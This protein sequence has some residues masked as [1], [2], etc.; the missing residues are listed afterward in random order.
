MAGTITSRMPNLFV[1]TAVTNGGTA[2]A[3]DSATA[4]KAR[5]ILIIARAAN[6]GTIFIGGS[7]VSSSTSKGFTAGQSIS[8]DSYNQPYI[9]ISDYYLDVSG[10]GE[11]IDYYG[12]R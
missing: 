11:G 8:W 6:T 10:D 2:V 7:D 3:L 9:T 4:G 12:V 5:S 1:G